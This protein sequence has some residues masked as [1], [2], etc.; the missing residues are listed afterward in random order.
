MFSLFSPSDTVN[1]NNLSLTSEIISQRNVKHIMMLPI[2]TITSVLKVSTN[3]ITSIAA[4]SNRL[5]V[6]MS[7]S[8]FKNAVILYIHI[9]YEIPEPYNLCNN[10]L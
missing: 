10:I 9:S 2:K 3:I 4:C 8:T 1:I 5:S 6:I 7:V